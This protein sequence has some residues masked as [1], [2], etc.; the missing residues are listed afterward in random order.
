MTL[1]HNCYKVYHPYE[2]KGI[3]SLS[4]FTHRHT[5]FRNFPM[6]Q[7]PYSHRETV[8]ENVQ[9]GNGGEVALETIRARQEE[10]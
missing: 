9:E 2:K 1:Q 6:P 8:R 3:L 7:H 5:S 10:T 4:N